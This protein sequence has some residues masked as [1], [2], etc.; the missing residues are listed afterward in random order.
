M[1]S[2]DILP[3]NPDRFQGVSE[4]SGR[5]LFDASSR[6]PN[7]S[8]RIEIHNSP[9]QELVGATTELAWNLNQNSEL[10]AYVDFVTTDVTFSEQ[11]RNSAATGR[12][13][14]K[15]LDGLK[16]VGPLESLAGAR[17]ENNMHVI[18][19]GPVQVVSS[20]ETSNKTRLLISKPPIQI[21]GQKK[22]LATF[23]K[24]AGEELWVIQHYNPATKSFEDG[25]EETI[26]IVKQPVNY[27]GLLVSTATE[28]DRSPVNHNGWYLYGFVNAENEMFQVEA[29]EPRQGLL[30]DKLDVLVLGETEAA[31]AL[32][33]EIWHDTRYKKGTIE[34]FLLD[35]T[36]AAGAKTAQEAIAEWR[37]GDRFLLLHLFGGIGGE[38]VNEENIMGVIPGHF[39]FGDATIV[40]DSFTGELQ[41]RIVYRQ[42]YANNNGGI[43][44][45][46]NMWSSYS[47]DLERGW[48]GRR[49]ISDVLVKL[50]PI[51]KT[52]QFDGEQVCPLDEM[53]RELNEMG[54]RYRSGDGDG[55]ALVSTAHSCVQDS[56]QALFA[57][58]NETKRRFLGNSKIQEWK[59]AHP[60][61]PQLDQLAVLRAM[62]E[63]LAA[64]LT[65]YG[66]R[67]DWDL[68]AK[69]LRGTAPQNSQNVLASLIE[70][71]RTWRTV[72]PRRAHDRL[73]EIFLKHG[74]KLWFIRTN[75]VGGYDSCTFPL[76]AARAFQYKDN[77]LHVEDRSTVSTFC[78]P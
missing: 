65:P 68:T 47:G 6:L 39:A 44:S 19:D 70:T 37:K 42:V 3:H 53:I 58:M 16:N 1:P 27:Q 4:W 15:R 48:F 46:P 14:P 38:I 64:Y 63:D 33:N 67:E 22:C 35:P 21:R 17:P 45:G 20:Q 52:Y 23:K 7:G 56:S 75:Q 30:I 5:L 31:S 40:E 51:T 54:A 10:K 26:K 57:A 41:F 76:A 13:H 36:V 77:R 78:C 11:T 62:E 50:D 12:I 71:I 60:D 69:G 66:V 29:W 25:D 34:T 72:I 49:P 61:D 59:K 32:E 9:H 2:S 28:I 74:A 43:I 55:C 8:V 73:C 18:L 24:P